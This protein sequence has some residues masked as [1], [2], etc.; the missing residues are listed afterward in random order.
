MKPLRLFASGS[1]VVVALLLIVTL[2]QGSHGGSAHALAAPSA[3]T[4]TWSGSNG[5]WSDSTKWSCGLVPGAADTA[6]VNS[7]SVSVDVPS[8]IGTLLFGGTTT[9]LTGAQP[10]TVSHAMTWTGLSQLL[11]VGLTTID[12]NATL[13]ISQTPTTMAF[14][15]PMLNKGRIDLIASSLFFN[16]VPSSGVFTNTNT[17]QVNLGGTGVFRPFQITNYGVVRNSDN[18]LDPALLGGGLIDTF[19]F[20]DN[21]GTIIAQNGNLNLGVGIHNHAGGNITLANGNLICYQELFGHAGALLTLDG[22]TLSGNGSADCSVTNAGGLIA[23][24]VIAISGSYTQQA[25]G[26]LNIQIGGPTLKNYNALIVGGSATLGGALNLSLINSYVPALFDGF[27]I[28]RY[29]THS[30][31]FATVVNPIAATH[32]LSYTADQV[33]LGTPQHQFQT[34]NLFAGVGHGLVKEYDPDGN[35]IAVLNTKTGS[36]YT[37]GMCF[38]ANGNLFAT[39]FDGYTVSKFN[40]AGKLISSTF[41]TGYPAFP[42][43]CVFD[44]AGDIYIGEVTPAPQTGALEK[45]DRNGTLISNFVTAPPLFDQR[46][47][48]WIDLAADQRT[49]LY[50]SEGARILAY[51]VITPAQKPDFAHSLPEP[52]YATRIRQ[53]GEVMTACSSAVFRFSPTG[54]VIMSYTA[55]SLGELPPRNPDNGLFALTLDSDGTSFWTAGYESGVVHRVDIATGTALK[56]FGASPFTSVAGLIVYGEVQVGRPG[57]ALIE[58]VGTDPAACAT[59]REITIPTTTTVTY[60]YRAIN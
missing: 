19:G 7:G 35:V 49:L 12:T 41:G 23:P 38:D 25:G 18:N 44:A 5:N 48:D 9:S 28:V 40:N 46:G 43:S 14:T 11:G 4:C 17:G 54:T 24:G 3:S 33:T 60:C 22:G 15:R 47:I 10:I 1:I 26:T 36:Q 21:Y 58:T 53:N 51:D 59:T 30:G 13:V 56:S 50:A 42:E 16:P 57:L 29:A 31:T 27:A 37:A 32:P 6:I 55:A 39:A 34:G 20:F 8:T 45:R 2:M 52:C